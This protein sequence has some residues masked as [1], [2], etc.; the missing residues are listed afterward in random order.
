MKIVKMIS[1]LGFVAGIA[2]SAITGNA[3]GAIVSLG[4]AS[5]NLGILCGERSRK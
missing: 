5:F 4:L 3:V 1:G 2:V